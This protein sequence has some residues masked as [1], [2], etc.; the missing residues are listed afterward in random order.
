MSFWA[1][2]TSV[3][4]SIFGSSCNI[5]GFTSRTELWSSPTVGKLP[6][7]SA[8]E[9]GEPSL[10]EYIIP[11]LNAKSFSG[12]QSI[13]NLCS[14]FFEYSVQRWLRDIHYLSSFFLFFTFQI[15]QSNCF[16]FIHSQIN[17]FQC[18]Q[19][20]PLWFK[21]FHFWSESNP[22]RLP[23]PWHVYEYIFITYKDFP[24]STD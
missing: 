21:E 11:S 23:W 16:Q 2:P 8:G 15:H 9:A 10:Y 6:F 22:P 24:L 18:M 20:H 1:S 19:W 3:R 17:L 14:G 4:S 5:G 13:C 7:M 12:N